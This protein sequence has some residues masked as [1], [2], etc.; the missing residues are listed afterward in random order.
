MWLGGHLLFDGTAIGT[1][2]NPPSFADAVLV[3][4]GSK[5]TDAEVI[6]AFKERR[7]SA[8]VARIDITPQT[9]E[10]GEFYP[11]IYRPFMRNA[12]RTKPVDS[13][14]CLDVYDSDFNPDSPNNCPPVPI[15]KVEYFKA[16]SQLVSLS[17]RLATVFRTVEAAPSNFRTYGDEIRSLLILACTEV[18]AQWKGILRSNGYA[19]ERYKTCDY[20]KLL[21]PLR[22]GE[23]SV[24]LSMHPRIP[25]VAP[26]SKWDS[27]NPTKSLT[28]YDAYNATKHDRE[29]SF[30]RAT[31]EN[32][33][34]A[35]AACAI[36]LVT[37]Y[38]RRST[39]K[40]EL[41]DL[42]RFTD[43]PAWRKEEMYL[44]CPGQSYT[45]VNH[46]F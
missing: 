42:F 29:E 45:P 7:I 20:V 30:S 36:L 3:P 12:G 2:G 6:Q 41:R 1:A 11:R 10:Y 15:D 44:S 40:S 27:T 13:I 8:T 39:W 35:V 5:P 43:V 31:V 23:Y 4:S 34:L 9:L 26:F 46:R 38:G 32:A 16:L 19:P 37:Q 14:A 17:N 24:E 25:S 28:W 21:T 22:L 33:M 18:E